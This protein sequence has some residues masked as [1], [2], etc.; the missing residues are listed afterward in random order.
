QTEHEVLRGESEPEGAVEARVLD[1]AA[2]SGCLRVAEVHAAD[3]SRHGQRRWS[4]GA[5]RL[6]PDAKGTGGDD[7]LSYRE[8]AD[9]NGYPPLRQG[10]LPEVLQGDV[11][12]AG[13]EGEH[14]HGVHRVCL[15]HGLVRPVRRRSVV[16]RG[17]AEPGRVLDGRLRNAD[18]AAW[19]GGPA[20]DHAA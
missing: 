15:G 10:P 20:A 7:E 12:A 6:R 2:D 9:G 19:P 13:G 16:D 8:A 3:P 4:A 14:E 18:A 5:L 11:L 17:T 1:A